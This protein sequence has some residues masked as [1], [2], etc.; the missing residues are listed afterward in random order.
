MGTLWTW[1]QK[2]TQ[3]TVPWRKQTHTRTNMLS[4]THSH[5]TQCYLPIGA[6]IYNFMLMCGDKIWCKRGV[7]VRKRLKYLHLTSMYVSFQRLAG[8]KC[9]DRKWCHRIL[10][11]V[12]SPCS[13]ET[14]QT[15]SV[16][17]AYAPSTVVTGS[18]VCVLI[19]G[20]K[21]QSF[22]IFWFF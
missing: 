5:H 16:H 22:R 3:N 12:E 18:S 21:N 8:F 15:S 4:L 7:C 17:S 20:D 19:E 10:L 11:N 9:L 2:F 1:M 14:S 13:I 6:Q